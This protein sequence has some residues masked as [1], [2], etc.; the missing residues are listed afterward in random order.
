MAPTYEYQ[1][2]H[3]KLVTEE[4]FTMKNRPDFI[5]CKE[6]NQQAKRVISIGMFVVN[7]AN[8]ANKYSGDSNYRWTGDKN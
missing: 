2:E 1:C 4:D 8:A 3:C 7:G 6:C 5:N